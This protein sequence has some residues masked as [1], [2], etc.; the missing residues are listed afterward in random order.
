MVFPDLSYKF[1]KKIVFLPFYYYNFLFLGEGLVKQAVDKGKS[2]LPKLSPE[3]QDSIRNECSELE[4][5]LESLKSLHRE[6]SA[7]IGRCLTAWQDFTQARDAFNSWIN[8]FRNKVILNYFFK[9]RYLFLFFHTY[10]M[11]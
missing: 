11:C 6:T 3:G 10:K 8:G 2:I 1:K 9:D 5:S 7:N 4:S